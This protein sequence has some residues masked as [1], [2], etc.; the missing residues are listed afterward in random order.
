MPL[1]GSL[2]GT[3]G[4]SVRGDKGQSFPQPWGVE[5]RTGCGHLAASVLLVLKPSSPLTT[6]SHVK[7]MGHVCP[8]G[9]AEHLAN[10]VRICSRSPSKLAGL[11][12][13]GGAGWGGGGEDLAPC[14]PSRSL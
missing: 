5:G 11:A 13:R 10:R 3:R 14:P 7:V 9:K 1:L 6:Q 8:L 12:P 2:I 4:R